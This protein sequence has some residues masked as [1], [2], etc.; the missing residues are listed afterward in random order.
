[1]LRRFVTEFINGGDESVLPDL[2][3]EDYLYRSPGEEVSGREELTAM[4]RG[5]RSAFP[6]MVLTSHRIIANDDTTVLDFTL[7]GTQRGEFMGIPATNRAIDIRGVVISRYRDGKIV[8][9]W[10]ILDS[11]T[12]LQQLEVA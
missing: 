4:F 11:L 5:L 12:M 3:H 1:M 2:I 6:D 8:H 7:K 9:D 10:E